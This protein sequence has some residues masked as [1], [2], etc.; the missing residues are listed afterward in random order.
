[1]LFKGLNSGVDIL[2]EKKVVNT[3]EDDFAYERGCF[4]GVLGY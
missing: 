1:A 2:L 3:Q 4:I